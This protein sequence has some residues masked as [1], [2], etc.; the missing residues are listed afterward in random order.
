MHL[1][2]L[3]PSV[4][5]RLSRAIYQHMFSCLASTQF[6]D[7]I[8]YFTNRNFVLVCTGYYIFAS[9]IILHF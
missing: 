5:H 2:F 4:S 3:H 1:P 6:A 8:I 9:L 7:C